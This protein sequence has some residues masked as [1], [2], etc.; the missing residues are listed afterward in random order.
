MTSL[1]HRQLI[2]ARQYRGYSQ[3]DLSSKISGLSQS[4]LSKFEKGVSTLSE[5]IIDKVILYLNFPKSFFHQ[6]ISNN[7]DTA[8]F[9]KRTTITK[10]VKTDIE[11]SFKLIGYIVDQMSDALDW[12][13]FNF[14]TF[15]LEEGYTPEIVAKNTRKLV[16][17][18]PH[19]PI[20][21]IF[22]L[23]ESNGI[24]IVEFNATEKF[25]GVSFVSDN[26]NPIIVINK[27]FCND[28]KRFTIAH[29]LGHLLMHSVN[30]P[31]IPS[32]REKKLE[33]EANKFASEF[34]MPAETIL[35]SLFDLRL[36]YL[37][38]LKKYWLTSMSS[39]IRRAKDLGCISYDRY[40]Y[41]NIEF[42]RKGWKKD[43][44]FVSVPIDEP[45]LFTKGYSMHKI[46][47]AYS[48]LELSEAFSLPIDIIK[49]FCDNSKRE[50]KLRVLI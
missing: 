40:K 12:P 24:I 23:I 19:E 46:E 3:T 11:L 21:E 45:M 38:E 34:L 44:S 41:L 42:S 27:T 22:N 14:K 13:N 36:S 17:L 47:L 7:T 33:N 43:E 37:A 25:D 30:N 29:E 28:R 39:I 4:N 2:F 31:A 15:D 32:H 8:H 1:N 5:E 26:G 48:D 50:T 20:N 9:R 49:R 16:G 10:K 6:N 35:N 18:K